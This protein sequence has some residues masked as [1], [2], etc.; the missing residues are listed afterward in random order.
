MTPDEQD[1]VLVLTL[2]SNVMYTYSYP[3]PGAEHPS[4]YR[5]QVDGNTQP[6]SPCLACGKST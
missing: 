4:Q 6:S 5:E 3:T 1:V 2:S